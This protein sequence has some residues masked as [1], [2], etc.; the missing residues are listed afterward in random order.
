MVHFYKNINI[1]F[2]EYI[3]SIIKIKK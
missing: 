1:Y 3:D 2:A